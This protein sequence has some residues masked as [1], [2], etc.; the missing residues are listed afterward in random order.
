[1]IN[2]IASGMIDF[3]PW[4]ARKKASKINLPFAENKLQSP[5]DPVDWR[6]CNVLGHQDSFTR[7]QE[8][9][10]RAGDSCLDEQ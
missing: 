5:H 7:D 1:V 6:R 4:I 10:L 8:V 9:Q 2:V 3:A